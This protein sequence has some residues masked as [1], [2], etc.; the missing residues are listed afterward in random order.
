MIVG[1]QTS[2]MRKP[3]SGDN[4]LQDTNTPYVNYADRR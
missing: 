1:V 3:M 2:A 4:I